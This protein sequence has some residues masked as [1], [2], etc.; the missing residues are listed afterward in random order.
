MEETTNHEQQEYI[1]YEISRAVT[2]ATSPSFTRSIPL[3]YS[4]KSY[5]YTHV[6]LAAS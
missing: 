1:I 2:V 3:K 4:H 6:D 5:A